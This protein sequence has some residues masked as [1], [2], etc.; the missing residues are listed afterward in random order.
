MEFISHLSPDRERKYISAL[1]LAQLCEYDAVHSHQVARLALR[2][3]DGLKPEHK[4]EEEHRFW[5]QCASILHDIGWIEGQKSHHKASLAIILN[6]HQLV[7]DNKERLIIGSIARYHRQSP[8]KPEH[9]HFAALENKEK[10]IVTK[11]A[12]ILRVADGLDHSHHAHIRD[13]ECKI[14][15]HKITLK[16]TA[17]SSHLDEE[18]YAIFKGDLFM[19]TF[20]KNLVIDWH[21]IDKDK[22]TRLVP[23]NKPPNR[24]Q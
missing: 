21:I 23:G 4:L 13:I 24:G 17:S 22:S 14:K 16:C 20:N 5:L 15:D 6:A 8:P 9:D 12:A 11:L 3:F 2:L 10:K 1:N 19:L 7:F 18:R